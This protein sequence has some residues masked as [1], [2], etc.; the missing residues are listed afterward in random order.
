MK[1]N[2]GFFFFW[3]T[4][5]VLR[6]CLKERHTRKKNIYY[7]LFEKVCIYTRLLTPTIKLLGHLSLGN[8]L[9]FGWKEGRCFQF[10]KLPWYSNTSKG[11]EHSWWWINE[12]QYRQPNQHFS[13]PLY[14][15]WHWC[16]HRVSHMWMSLYD[17]K[18]FI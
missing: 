6:E 17:N 4:I 5:Q 8:V 2:W 7:L 11:E 14:E 16:F 1:C 12:F 18:I 9:S 3:Y 15:L 10:L 13:N